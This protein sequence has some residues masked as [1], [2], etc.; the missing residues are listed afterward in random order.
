MAPPLGLGMWDQGWALGSFP[1]SLS[2]HLL[3]QVAWPAPA[4][5]ARPTPWW[6]PTRSPTCWTYTCS[7]AVL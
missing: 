4:E 7:W 2:D 3:L 5:A 1:L 6:P